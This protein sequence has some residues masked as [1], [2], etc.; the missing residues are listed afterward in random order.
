MNTLDPP[1][2]KCFILRTLTRFAS[3]SNDT[4]L[5]V[6]FPVAMQQVVGSLVMG[7]G[8]LLENGVTGKIIILNLPSPNDI[9]VSTN[10]AAAKVVR[11]QAY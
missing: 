2:R 11:T 7:V 8:K 10:R 1:C 3:V 4:C 5:F 6:C 9:P